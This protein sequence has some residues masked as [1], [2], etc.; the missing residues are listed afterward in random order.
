MDNIYLVAQEFETPGNCGALARVAENFD[1]K[2]LVFLNPK[3]DYRSKESLDRAAHAKGLLEK[4]QVVRTFRE[5]KKRF[6]YVIGTTSIISTDY[7]IPRSPLSPRQFAETLNRKKFAIVIGREGKGLTNEEISECDFIV[8][9]QT[10]KKY[11][12]MNVSHA[13][14]IILYEVF[15]RISTSKLADNIPFATAKD[16]EVTVKLAMKALD[17]MDFSTEER[18]ITQQRLWKRMIGKSFLTKREIFALC[19]FFKKIK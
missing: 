13:A 4:A 6:D 15:N 5:L 10:S 17:K 2:N 12:A 8:T 11:P 16:R 14:A 7:N 1:C 3:C 9:I 19:G 18:R